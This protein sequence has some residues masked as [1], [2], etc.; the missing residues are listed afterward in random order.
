MKAFSDRTIICDRQF[1]EL[2]GAERGTHPTD[3]EFMDI[4]QKFIFG[5]VSEVGSLDNQMRELITVTVLSVMQTLPQLKAH[6]GACL[7]VGVTPVEIREAVYQVAPFIGFPKTLNAIN[8][9]NEVFAQ[10][11]IALPLSPQGTVTDENRREKGAEVQAPLYGAEIKEKYRH[12][13]DFAAKAIPDFLTELAFGDFYTRD[14]LS[15][16]TRELLVVCILVTLGTLS[17]LKAHVAANEKLGNG[18]ERIYAA[19][20]Q[21]LPYIGFPSIFAAIDEIER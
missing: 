4:L 21:C 9:M 14:G 11:E 2:F 13:P 5:E 12:L 19:L 16:R 10:N 15:V 8:A 18:K 20:L 6:V 7:N 1:K 3:P 17:P